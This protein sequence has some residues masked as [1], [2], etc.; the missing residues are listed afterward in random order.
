[1]SLDLQVDLDHL[2]LLGHWAWTNKLNRF[3]RQSPMMLVLTKLG[4]DSHSNSPYDQSMLE[5]H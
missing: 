4:H 3:I 1:M 5:I 2:G